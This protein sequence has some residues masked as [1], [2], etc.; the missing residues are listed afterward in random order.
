MNSKGV[1]TLEAL[2]VVPVWIVFGLAAAV[3]AGALYKEAM[4]QEAVREM[5]KVV[6]AAS[7]VTRAF[8]TLPT[9]WQTFVIPTD[10]VLRTVQSP[11]LHEKWMVPFLYTFVDD[12]AVLDKRHIRIER[13][14]LPVDDARWF[15]AVVSYTW[16]IPIL[17]RS[18]VVRASAI[19]RCWYGT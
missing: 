4:L 14:A 15:G 10:A 6:A 19:E 5:V 2:L 3:C 12:V 18:I 11:Q 7:A 17:G 13:V 9:Q 16:H 8:P 1:A